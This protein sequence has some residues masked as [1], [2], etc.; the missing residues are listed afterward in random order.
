MRTVSIMT[1]Q[2]SSLSKC[3]A[4]RPRSSE[5]NHFTLPSAT[6][7]IRRTAALLSQIMLNMFAIPMHRTEIK[8]IIYRLPIGRQSSFLFK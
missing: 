4:R 3:V 6:G 1:L 5:S 7:Q 2:S 8:M